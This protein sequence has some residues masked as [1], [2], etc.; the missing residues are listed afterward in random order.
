[1]SVMNFASAFTS[2]GRLLE[3]LRHA[4]ISPYRDE[5]CNVGVER[6]P[7]AGACCLSFGALGEQRFESR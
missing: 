5:G 4:R 3:A 7:V 6:Q 1:M 2:R